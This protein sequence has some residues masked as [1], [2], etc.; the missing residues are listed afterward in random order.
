MQIHGWCHA[1]E[2][3]KLKTTDSD[4]IAACGELLAVEERLLPMLSEGTPGCAVGELVQHMSEL[5]APH[6]EQICACPA[7]TWGGL[8]AKARVAIPFSGDPS[9]QN[10]PAEERLAA[11]LLRDIEALAAGR[12]DAPLR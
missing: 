9:N 3:R 11:A 4:L 7:V 2:D 6:V 12:E 8:V 5:H 10:L 1:W